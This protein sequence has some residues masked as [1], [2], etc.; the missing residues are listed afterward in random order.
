M[1]LIINQYIYRIRATSWKRPIGM[2]MP[3]GI[4]RRPPV[5]EWA[6]KMW[7]PIWFLFRSVKEIGSKVVA[8]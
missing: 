8:T 7:L 1:I 2:K 6:V 5:K 3:I 4:Q